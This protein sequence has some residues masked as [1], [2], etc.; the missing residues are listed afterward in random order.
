M[1]LKKRCT[2]APAEK[3]REPARTATGSR[4]GWQ[5]RISSALIPPQDSDGVRKCI[6]GYGRAKEPG[7]GKAHGMTEAGREI[8][9]IR[10][11]S[12]LLLI[13]RKRLN[14]NP[15]IL[16]NRKLIVMVLTPEPRIPM[17][18]FLPDPEEGRTG[19]FARDDKHFI[20]AGA[21]KFLMIL[22]L[23]ASVRGDNG[24]VGSKL[25]MIRGAAAVKG[26]K[27]EL[28]GLWPFLSPGLPGGEQESSQ[29]SG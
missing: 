5:I 9:L 7:H 28:Q 27:G 21:P 24:N 25:R 8:L 6:A 18:H 12:L 20:I 26:M 17:R 19:L 10:T 15:E 3:R 11:G 23:I 13:L 22:L 29:N 2:P 14:S 4:R 1:P 16:G